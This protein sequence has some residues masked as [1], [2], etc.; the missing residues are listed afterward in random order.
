M[1]DFFNPT[2]FF[3][4]AIFFYCLTAIDC[5]AQTGNNKRAA[6]ANQTVYRVGQWVEVEMKDGTTMRAKVLYKK[7]R[8]NQYWLHQI[9]GLRQGICHA[10]YLRPIE[11]DHN[12]VQLAEGIQ[13]NSKKALAT[14]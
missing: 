13:T 11:E 3:T 9:G 12:Q 2:T 14:N 6:A 5:N 8:K 10:R 4:A 1:K 7:K